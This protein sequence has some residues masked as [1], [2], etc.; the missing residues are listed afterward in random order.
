[1]P[2]TM[3]DGGLDWPY[4]NAAKRFSSVAMTKLDWSGWNELQW[5]RRIETFGENDEPV[6]ARGGRGEADGI[7]YAF[8]VLIPR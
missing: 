5:R 6:I 7:W 4:C 2:D 8:L 3:A 1:M